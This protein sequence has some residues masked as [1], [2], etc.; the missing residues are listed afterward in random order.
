MI[1]DDFDKLIKRLQK[2][3]IKDAVDYDSTL[4]IFR[5]KKKGAISYAILYLYDSDENRAY[6]Y[7]FSRI[8]K[9]INQDA[10]KNLMIKLGRPEI[11][12]D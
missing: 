11:A 8:R 7:Y 4:Q 9:D 1:D 10:L 3:M 5:K 6:N 2:I 12:Y